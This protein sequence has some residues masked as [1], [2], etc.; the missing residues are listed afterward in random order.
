MNAIK[1][2][3]YNLF[4]LIGKG[5][6][7][8]VYL[9]SKSN[10]SEIYATKRIEISN[11][12][13]QK[14]T[15]SKYISNEI[16]IMKELDHPN[17]IKLH[18]LYRTNNHLYFIMDYC[19]GG[20]LSS[21]LNDYKLH[22]G[23]PFSHEII[24]HFMI[25]IVD[26]LKY[27]HSKNIIH[28]DI[29]L[30]NILLNFDNIEDKKNFNL[31]SAKI[32]IIDFGLATKLSPDGVAKTYAGTPL[33]MDPNILKKYN[34]A[35]GYLRLQGYNQKADIWSLGTI[36]FEMLTGEVLFKGEN[37]KDLV[38]QEDQGDYSIPINFELSKEIIDFLNSMIQYDPDMRI[39]AEE[40]SKH[41]FL[42]KNVKDFTI[43]KLEQI[44]NKIENGMLILNI[45]H[46]STII[47]YI[48]SEKK[49]EKPKEIEKEKIDINKTINIINKRQIQNK[50]IRFNQNPFVSTK[51]IE[52]GIGKKGIEPFASPMRNRRRNIFPEKPGN[53]DIQQFNLPG[54]KNYF[55]QENEKQVDL[56][57]KHKNFLNQNMD[58]LVNN[59]EMMLKY[60]NSLLKEY[61]NAKNYFNK[62][63]LKEQEIAAVN[64]CLVI[65][66]IKDKIESNSPY[67]SS[68]IPKP[69]TP[70]FIYGYS[71]EERNQRFINILNKFN[72]DKRILEQK[73]N[74]QRKYAITKNIIEEYKKKESQLEA[75]NSIIKCLE[76]NSK[77]KWAPAPKCI[78]AS[79][80]FQVEK[81]SYDNC[82]FKINFQ[83][84]KED[85]IKDNINLKISFKINE[86]KTLY[87]EVKLT[88]ENNFTEE[89]TCTLN[90]N[91]WKNIDNNSENFMLIMETDN[92]FENSSKSSIKIDLRKIKTGQKIGLKLSLLTMNNN[93]SVININAIP[94][95]PKGR[96]YLAIERN[97]ILI[98]KEIYPAFEGKI[99][100]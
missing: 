70:E 35:G 32:R 27:I 59:K 37:I 53:W 77:N 92:I 47:D 65:N 43:V 87:K 56:D 34:K 93:K 24:Q 25:Q 19:N 6:F 49:L 3:D 84:K 13:K 67:N 40:L 85:Y 23:K 57:K 4:K 81:I 44:S 36:C 68:K 83:V 91:E 98:L 78:L 48:K 72:Y 42:V 82:E 51:D 79:K 95:I 61:E 50:Y 8:E 99:L 96:K 100:T 16:K 41:D 64:K 20:S 60:I 18:N 38:E 31:L 90:S 17:I 14:E 30:D 29:K 5:T 94:L 11:D 12:E 55:S 7:G 66:D 58:L 88:M 89:W 39:S 45:K 80:K 52:I 22:F 63:K 62:N 97:N 28:R 73:M 9:T 46:N 69:I 26:G 33:N 54:I 71:K 10:N 75:I 76:N 1:I 21:I 15:T 2:N 74:S 86:T